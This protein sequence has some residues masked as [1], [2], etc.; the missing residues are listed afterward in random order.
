MFLSELPIPVITI[1]SSGNLIAGENY[2]LSCT[3]TVIDGL[4]DDALVTTSW[5]DREGN[6]LQSDSVQ[7]ASVNTTLTLDFFPLVLLHGGQYTC[8]ASVTIPAI[9][10]TKRN[11]EP[12]DITIQSNDTLSVNFIMLIFV[13]FSSPAEY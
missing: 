6:L 11:S 2:T 3:V 10:S 8:N 13:Y 9:T 4:V 1:S 5:T 7:I 12:Y